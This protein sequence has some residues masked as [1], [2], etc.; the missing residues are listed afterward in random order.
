M[1]KRKRHTGDLWLYSKRA[2][3][4]TRR[5]AARRIQR[6]FRNRKVKTNKQL[7]RAVRK[8]WKGR[9][10]KAHYVEN[11]ATTS[12]GVPSVIELTG[13]GAGESTNQHEGNKVQLRGL[14]VHGQTQVTV[15]GGVPSVSHPTRWCVLIVRS[16]LDVGIAGLPAFSRLYDDTNLPATMFLPDAF[17]Q[18]NN[19]DLSKVKILYKKVITLA[20]QT[21]DSAT[22]TSVYPMSKY[23]TIDLKLGKA[24]IEYREG[25]SVALNAQYYIMIMCASS[26]AAG[27][28]GLEHAFT[29]KLSFYDV[30]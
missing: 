24:M 29:S 9:A 26:G 5:R 4:A 21:Q 17:R 3:T 6:A 2:R 14:Q 8:L 28:L 19:E 1:P 10:I 20:A 22:A 27:N 18:L 23:W 30:E 15:A 11:T 25:T 12:T 13:I 7:T 16:T